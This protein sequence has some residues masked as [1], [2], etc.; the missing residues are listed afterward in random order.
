MR[1]Q[2]GWTMAKVE[3][4]LPQWGMGMTD[5]EVV[6]WL[7]QVGD[8]VREGDPLVEIEAAKVTEILE[9]PVSGTLVQILVNATETA[10]VR[11]VLAVIETGD[12]D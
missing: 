4:R 3:V 2:K 11:D 7:R 1:L 6:E 12:A 10:E 9:S 8:D 5:G